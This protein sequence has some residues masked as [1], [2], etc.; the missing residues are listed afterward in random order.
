LDK[1]K[2]KGKKAWCFLY[3]QILSPNTS[4][5]SKAKLAMKR[6]RFRLKEKSTFKGVKEIKRTIEK[7]VGIFW[8]LSELALTTHNFATLP[9]VRVLF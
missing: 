4:L 3:T 9:V 5:K 1:Q 6:S 8:T 2:S 7:L